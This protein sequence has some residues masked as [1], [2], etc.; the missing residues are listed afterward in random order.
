MTPYMMSSLFLSS[1]NLNLG[2]KYVKNK[3][4]LNDNSLFLIDFIVFRAR[5][6]AMSYESII[7]FSRLGLEV[8]YVHTRRRARATLSLTQARPSAPANVTAGGGSAGFPPRERGF[9]LDA[10]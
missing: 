6:L 7:L 9:P 8:E 5:V 10:P 4:N 3:C 1:L 2:D